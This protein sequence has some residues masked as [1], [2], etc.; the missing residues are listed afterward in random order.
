[1]SGLKS[2]SAGGWRQ[3]KENGVRAGI[4]VCFGLGSH[5][6][7][8]FVRVDVAFVSFP[9]KITQYTQQGESETQKAMDIVD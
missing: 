7:I 6:R 8:R 3:H 1:M 2:S 4:K 5:M 9:C